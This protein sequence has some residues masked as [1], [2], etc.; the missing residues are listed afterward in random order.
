MFPKNIGLTFYGAFYK[1]LLLYL[2][3]FFF[4]RTYFIF[5][6]IKCLHVW[7]C[8]SYVP[9]TLEGQKR[10]L[11]A[12]KLELWMVLSHHVSARD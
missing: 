7:M 5:M 8:T 4:K 1:Q 9:G 12:L 6:C 3:D 2:V 10:A 11:Y